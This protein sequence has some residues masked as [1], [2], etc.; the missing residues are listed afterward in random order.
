MHHDTEMPVSVKKK[1]VILEKYVSVN[2]AAIGKERLDRKPFEVFE[3]GTFG[4][5]G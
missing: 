4:E 5:S 3:V 1:I 2:T